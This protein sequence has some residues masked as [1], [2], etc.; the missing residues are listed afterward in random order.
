VPLSAYRGSC[1]PS[2][3][4]GFFLWQKENSMVKR[5]LFGIAA[6]VAIS[7]VA[8]A[9]DKG[10]LQN[11]L[12]KVADAP[13]YSWSSTTE[14]AGGFGG[15]GGGAPAA[16]APLQIVMKGEKTVVKV[17]DAWK[18]TEELNAAIAA[19]PAAPAG[20]APG[21]APAGGPGGGAPGGFGGGGGGG[22]GGRGGGR[23]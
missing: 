15:G 2:F 1:L 19:P 12:K 3:L 18:T 6:M 4:S 10:D 13:S 9:D 20:G 11:A 5:A 7:S 23:G 22:G 16:P 21:A 17:G 14:N 8:F